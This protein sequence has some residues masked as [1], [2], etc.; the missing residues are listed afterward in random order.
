[1]IPFVQHLTTSSAANSSTTNF[2]LTQQQSSQ[3][4][5]SSGQHFIAVTSTDSQSPISVNATAIKLLP[6]SV[7]ALAIQQ[8][9]QQTCSSSGSLPQ[10]IS[11]PKGHIIISGQSTNMVTTTTANQLTSSALLQKVPNNQSVS[12]PGQTLAFAIRQQLPTQ[13][14]SGA[15]H[16]GALTLK[17]SSST[18]SMQHINSLATSNLCQQPSTIVA[19][20]SQTNTTESYP[21]VTP[22]SANS[23]LL[24]TLASS[25]STKS[26]PIVLMQSSQNTNML[27][28]NTSSSVSL[29]NFTSSPTNSNTSRL[30]N[31]S[32]TNKITTSTQTSGAT[33]GSILSTNSKMSPSTESHFPCLTNIVSNKPVTEPIQSPLVEALM[34]P[35]KASPSEHSATSPKKPI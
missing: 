29:L 12:S 32:Y 35:I 14:Q 27:S 2:I 25:V 26:I 31:T 1:M 16:L 9:Q 18:V 34:S 5:T 19:A 21:N 24:R 10:N 33:L 7:A 8:N 17:S 4:K 22:V 20:L 6:S 30:I 15:V 23:S 3:I 28:S 11:T 13:P